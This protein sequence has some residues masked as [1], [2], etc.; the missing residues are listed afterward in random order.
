M[1]GKGQAWDASIQ[2]DEILGNETEF[3]SRV[4]ASLLDFKMGVSLWCV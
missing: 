2:T 1:V 4:T 3:C